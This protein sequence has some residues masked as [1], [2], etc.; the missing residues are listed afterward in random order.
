MT[1]PTVTARPRLRTHE[2][3]A[4]ANRRIGLSRIRGIVTEVEAKADG[5]WVTVKGIHYWTRVKP[6]ADQLRGARGKEVEFSAEIGKGPE[7]ERCPV[8][9]KVFSTA[10]PAPQMNST[11]AKPNATPA[12]NNRE[13]PPVSKEELF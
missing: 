4:L 8:I 12:T 10:S 9:T 13:T 2:R 1:P 6:F 11:A 3:P 5:W 7:N